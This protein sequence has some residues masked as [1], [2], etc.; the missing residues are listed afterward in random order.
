MEHTP[1]NLLI[2]AIKTG[3]KQSTEALGELIQAI[4]G[5][6]TLEKLFYPEGLLK[7]SDSERREIQESE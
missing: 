4:D 2:R 6:L 3:K 7:T 5:E 1:K